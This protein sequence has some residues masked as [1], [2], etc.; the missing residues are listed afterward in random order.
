MF[1][2][3]IRMTRDE[4]AEVEDAV[5]KLIPPIP[6]TFNGQSLATAA[7]LTSFTAKLPTMIAGDDGNLRPSVRQGN[8]EVYAGDP[9]GIL[10]LGIPVCDTDWPWRLNVM[11]KVPLNMDRNEVTNAF[12]RALQVAAMNA[13]A[14]TLDAEQ[15]ASPW[16][17][18]AIGDSRI[19][20]AAL[21]QILIQRFGERAVVAVPGDPVANATAEANGSQVIH[22]GAMSADVW[23]NI[24]KHNLISSSSQAFPTPKPSP[25]G[26]SPEI[27]PLCKQLIRS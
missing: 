18:E 2:G 16:A 14:D 20:L 7:L 3:E 9:G 25:A 11:Q 6:T 17:T 24:R 8:V 23:A 15:A 1:E 27:C 10:E 12:R 4:L 26:K 13:L 5:T 21:K 22:G 19:Q